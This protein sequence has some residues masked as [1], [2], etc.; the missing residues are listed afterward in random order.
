MYL[1]KERT[2][3]LIEATP[4]TRYWKQSIACKVFWNWKRNGENYVTMMLAWHFVLKVIEF[5]EQGKPEHEYTEFDFDTKYVN[6]QF[7]KR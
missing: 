3:A 5:I 4:K 1:N 6:G 2:A 7:I